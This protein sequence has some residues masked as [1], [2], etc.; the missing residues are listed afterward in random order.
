M[1]SLPSG[2]KGLFSSSELTQYAEAF[3]AADTDNS[4]ALDIHE[5]NA[6][7]DK[8]PK[9]IQDN[10]PLDDMEQML[11]SLDLNGDGVV[12]FELRQLATRGFAAEEL[13]FLTDQ[14]YV[15]DRDWRKRD[16]KLM[17]I[18]FLSQP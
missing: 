11:R 9:Q 15:Q 5:L 8:L 1:L 10:I 14:F 3:V 6:I 16:A 4:G 7:I 12:S 18:T 13:G 17:Q 2:I